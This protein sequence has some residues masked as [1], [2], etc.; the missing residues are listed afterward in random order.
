MRLCLGLMN[1]HTATRLHY[2]F[3]E[4]S[5]N[6]RNLVIPPVDTCTHVGHVTALYNSSSKSYDMV[7]WPLRAPETPMADTHPVVYTYT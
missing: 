4:M 2:W 7:F 1:D 3:G 6:L 5:R